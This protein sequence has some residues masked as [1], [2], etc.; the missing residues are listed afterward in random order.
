MLFDCDWDG[1]ERVLRNQGFAL[2]GTAFGEPG[3]RE[4]S[5]L[6]AD[7]GL[8]R[9]RIS[10]ERYRFGRGEYQYFAYP[11]PDPVAAAR[12][13]AYRGLAP[14]ASRWMGDLGAAV[15]Y[16]GE[17]VEFLAQCHAAG[18][19]R[20]TPLMLKYGAGDFNCLHQDLYG[21]VVFPIQVVVGLS[22]PGVDYGGG[23]LMLVEQQPRAQS[24][25]RVVPLGQGEAVAITTRYR[26]VKGTRGYYRANVRHG[27]STVTW[28][29]RFTLGL[30]FHDAV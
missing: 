14:I 20:P 11:L 30:I 28:G 24:I 22:R 23:E 7:G 26:P 15:E 18:Q 5:G 21:D 19:E 8:F 4:V 25:G 3:C 17:L 1:V 10:M 2:L 27:V 12:E 16:P 6:Y 9:S 29:E 13:A